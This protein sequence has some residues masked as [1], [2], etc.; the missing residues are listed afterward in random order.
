MCFK[1]TYQ[2][3][4]M[5]VGNGGLNDPEPFDVEGWFEIEAAA[6]RSDSRNHNLGGSPP[7]STQSHGRFGPV[8]HRLHLWGRLLLVRARALH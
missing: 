8:Q 2:Q 1:S 7:G 6:A 3:A 5:S 4:R